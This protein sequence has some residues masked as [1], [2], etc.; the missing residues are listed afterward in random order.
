MTRRN[1]WFAHSSSFDAHGTIS[2]LDLSAS[3]LPR[4]PAARPAVPH[5]RQVIATEQ[6]Q[7]PV[8]GHGGS[9]VA[10]EYSP[11]WHDALPHWAQDSGEVEVRRVGFEPTT[12]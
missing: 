3:R 7:L 2:I 5:F 8:N 1:P 12:G 10:E 11:T 6:I 4:V 9:H